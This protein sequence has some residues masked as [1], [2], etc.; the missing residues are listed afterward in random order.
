MEK[1]LIEPLNKA[2]S[3]LIEGMKEFEQTH[4]DLIRDGCI[5]RFEYTYELANKFI[6]RFLVGHF[7]INNDNSLTHNQVLRE[8]A[9][10]GLVSDVELW[11]EF[12]KAR[13]NTTHTYDEDNANKVIE[14]VPYFINEVKFLIKRFKAIIESD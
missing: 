8:A 11:F 3:C 2:F 9:K 10:C 13:N 6:G 5:Q 4:N 14:V 1:I 12:K 7:N